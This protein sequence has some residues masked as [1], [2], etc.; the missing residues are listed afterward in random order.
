MPLALGLTKSKSV[1]FDPLLWLFFGTNLFFERLGGMLHQTRNLTNQP[2]EHF[3][4]FGYFMLNVVLMVML[5]PALGLYAYPVAMLGTQLLF[6]VWFNG[7]I[8]YH[9]I[10]TSALSFERSVGIPALAGL[11]IVGYLLVF[12]SNH[13]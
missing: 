3:G 5:Q 10:G 8:A 2:M 13:S 7:A 12:W 6:A 9:V 4:M 11:L 1:T